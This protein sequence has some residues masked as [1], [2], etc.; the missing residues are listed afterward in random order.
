MSWEE[1]YRRDPRMIVGAGKRRR[2][3]GIPPNWSERAS[4]SAVRDGRM[5][6]LDADTLTRPTLRLAEGVASVCAAL[7]KAR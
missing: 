5:A 1:L 6:Y 4:L 3:G 2:R 7:E